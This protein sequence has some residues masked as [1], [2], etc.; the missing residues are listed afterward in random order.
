MKNF[1]ATLSLVHLK[2]LA[3]LPIEMGTSGGFDPRSGSDMTAW[4]P[5][6]EATVSGQN[7]GEDARELPTDRPG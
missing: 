6:V 5:C 7:R 2:T 3:F 1:L 4:L